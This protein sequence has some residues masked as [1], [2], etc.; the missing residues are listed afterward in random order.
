MA[1]RSRFSTRTVVDSKYLVP[2]LAAD[3]PLAYSPT[4]PPAKDYFFQYTWILPEIFD[5]TVNLREHRYFGSPFKDDAGFLFDFWTNVRNDGGAAIPR[6]CELGL[7]SPHVIRTPLAA[8]RHVRKRYKTPGFVLM[9][10][11]S[12]QWIAEEDQPLIESGEVVLYRGIGQADVF[13]QLRFRPDYLSSA[14]R[15]IWRKYL[16][17]Q[18]EMLS[19]S[20]L[21]FNTI[22]DRVR[23]CESGGL[24]DGTW[25]ADQWTVAAGLDIQLPGC[26]KELWESAQQSY[27]LDPNMGEIKF[28][29]HYVAV[30]T[31]LSNIRIT[32]FFAGESEVKIVDPSR[33]HEVRP[34]GCD[35]QFIAPTEPGGDTAPELPC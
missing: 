8:Y 1:K 27:S 2:W 33:I 14:N 34:F 24:L 13:R 19:D 26:A 35:V 7:L 12:Y 22:H 32:T 11:G 10:H 21:S 6:Y 18:A 5:Q 17:L 25:L 31:A 3:G 4:E 20:T 28:G 30:R 15:E 29:P 23:R 9:Q 16:A